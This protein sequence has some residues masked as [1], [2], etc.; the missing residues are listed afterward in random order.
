MEESQVELAT[1]A[2]LHQGLSNARF[3]P[4]PGDHWDAV[5]LH[6]VLN[7]IPDTFAI[8]A[9]T[10]R[11]LK[12]GGILASRDLIAESS[13]MEPDIGSLNRFFPI[14]AAVMAAND[15]HPQLGRQMRARLPFI[16]QAISYGIASRE[17]LDELQKNALLWG[18][19]PSAFAAT[20][21]GQVIAFKP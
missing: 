20:A 2:A 15:G 17:E 12:S 16:D 10:L 4:F 18:E 13:F 19:H 14:F 3:Q 1:K 11:V 7:H 9:E 8:L 5:H 6:G 21:W